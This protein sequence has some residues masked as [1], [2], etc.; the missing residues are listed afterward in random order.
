MDVFICFHMFR[1][2]FKLGP[3]LPLK[4]IVNASQETHGS[5]EASNKVTV[6]RSDLQ[7]K[8]SGR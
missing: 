7:P 1:K 4:M 2:P 8:A 5:V 6:A 3:V